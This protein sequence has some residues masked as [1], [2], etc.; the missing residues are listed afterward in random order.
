MAYDDRYVAAALRLS[1]LTSGTDPRRSDALA[2][3]VLALEPDN[4]DAHERLIRNAQARRDH[5]SLRRAIR[6]YEQAMAA[7]GLQPNPSVVRAG[8]PAH[9]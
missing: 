4:E 3:Q 7:V 2:E 1:E 8:V 5:S 6:R 9:T